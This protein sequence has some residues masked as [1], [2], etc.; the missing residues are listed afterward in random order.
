M[1]FAVEYVGAHALRVLVTKLEN[2]PNFDRLGHF[3]R[4]SALWTAFSFR[5]IAHIGGKS[6]REVASRSH[7]AEVVLFLIRPGNQIRPVNKR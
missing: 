6:G 1:P 4:R 2:V 7:I 3:Q 5:S